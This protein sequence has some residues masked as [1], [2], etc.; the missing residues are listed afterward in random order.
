MAHNICGP[1]VLA[2]DPDCEMASLV[3][4]EN[5]YVVGGYNYNNC[6]KRLPLSDKA[7]TCSDL[8]LCKLYT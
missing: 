4:N 8:A 6:C 7:A 5:L 2:L 3:L 1:V